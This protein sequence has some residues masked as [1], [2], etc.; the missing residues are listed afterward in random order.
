MTAIDIIKVEGRAL[1]TAFI[2]LPW[3]LYRHNRWWVPPLIGEEH[4]LFDKAANA[5]FV[6]SDADFFLARQNGRFVG[7]IAAFKYQR[8][9]DKFNDAT[10]FFG[11]FECIDDQQVATALFDAAVAW[12]KDRQLKRI[13]GPYNFTFDDGGGLLIDG[14]D[15]VPTY[16]MNYNHDYYQKLV[17]GVGFNKMLDLY[18]YDCDLPA[19]DISRLQKVSERALGRSNIR[20]DTVDLQQFDRDVEACYTIY[21]EAFEGS[22]GTV[23]LSREKFR[24]M[25]VSLRKYCDPELFYIARQHD[26]AVAIAVV[27]PDL[28]PLIQRWNGRLFPRAWLDLCLGSHKKLQRVRMVLTATSP[29]YQRLGIDAALLQ[30]AMIDCKRKGYVKAEASWIQESTIRVQ[31]P[32]EKI[33]FHRSKTYRLYERQL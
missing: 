31:K 30:R 16:K 22:I 7:R 24:E 11:F 14:F 6:E 33:G 9:L 17:T 25:A 1:R 26:K 23:D 4:A 15:D 8:H 2:K 19:S 21:R 29:N 27:M 10:A 12:S 20:I 28:N 18:T 32:L 3:E 13:I 5:F